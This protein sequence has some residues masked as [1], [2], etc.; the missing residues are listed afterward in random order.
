MNTI[1]TLSNISYNTPPFFEGVIASLVK[2]GVI[3]YAYWILH[4]PDIDEQKPHIHFVFRPSK[5]IDTA[6]FRE[7]FFEYESGNTKP[8][9]P[10]TKFFAT[11]SMDDWLLYAVH[12]RSYLISKG[13]KRNISYAFDDIKSTD[14]DALRFDWNNID[15]TKYERLQFLEQAIE[16]GTPYYRLVQSGL[17]PIGQRAQYEQQYNAIL[18]YSFDEISHR[19][20]SHE[21]PTEDVYQQFELVLDDDNSI[22]F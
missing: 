7:A 6:R 20:R 16:E 4:Q 14:P 8:L 5:R 15:R 22:V 19:V 3:D 2:N 9:C 17:I 1:R 13:Q 11:N 12:D 21:E 18:K 10:T